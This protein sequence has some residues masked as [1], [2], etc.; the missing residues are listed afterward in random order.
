M[1]G[2][3]AARP[4]APGRRRCRR[5]PRSSRRGR[6]GSRS[7]GR[8]ARCASPRRC[9]AVT[10]RVRTRPIVQARSVSPK[11]LVRYIR[12]LYHDLL[13]S[14]QVEY[15]TIMP[16]YVFV[17]DS[18]L[19][20][21]PTWH[22]SPEDSDDESAESPFGALPYLPV[23]SCELKC[24]TNPIIST[25]YTGFVERMLEVP[26]VRINYDQYTRPYLHGPTLMAFPAHIDGVRRPHRSGTG[27]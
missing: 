11:T 23:I 25:F 12:D 24:S 22:G 13:A 15:W 16:E 14:G 2:A 21:T 4:P 20:H 17:L 8:S 10:R 26:I 19:V 1:Q 27:G 3:V 5:L 7:P 6:A 18:C 9:A